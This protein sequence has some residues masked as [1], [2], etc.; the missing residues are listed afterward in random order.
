MTQFLGDADLDQLKI[1]AAEAELFD[2]DKRLELFF[3]IRRLRGNIPK[4]GAPK[5]QLRQ[6]LN[7]LNTTPPVDGI[8]PLLVWLQNA[9]PLV[10]DTDQ[11]DYFEDLLARVAGRPAGAK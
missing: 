10:A 11:Q 4:A 3:R 5:G 8:P 9:R 2:D 1:H 7:Y 6:D